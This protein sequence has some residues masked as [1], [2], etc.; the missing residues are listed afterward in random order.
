MLSGRLKLDMFV[1][2]NNAEKKVYKRYMTKL[3]ILYV[4]GE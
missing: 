4:P 2:K 3:V 1:E